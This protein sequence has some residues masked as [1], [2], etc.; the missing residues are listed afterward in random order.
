L[1]EANAH[2]PVL[3]AWQDLSKQQRAFNKEKT[4]TEEAFQKFVV[5][6]AQ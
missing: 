1:A 5:E 3:E 6:A 4:N 2:I